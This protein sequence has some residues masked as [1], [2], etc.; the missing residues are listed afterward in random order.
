MRD[1]FAVQSD[2][3]RNIVTALAVT[4]TDEEKEVVARRHT[5]SVE[6]YDLF[7]QGQAYYV[8]NLRDDNL[9]ARDY[10][11]RALTLDDGF[12]RAHAALALTYADDFRFSWGQDPSVS[13]LAALRHAERA[14]AL[15]AR[16]P[17]AHFVLGYVHLF[18]HKNHASALKMG[19]RTVA[20]DPNHADGHALLAVSHVY[21]GDPETAVRH[22]ER[23]MRLNPIHPVR[24]LSILGYAHYF[25]GRYDKA[26]AAL[27]QALEQNPVRLIPQL[28]LV[29]SLVRQGK[30]SDDPWL[31]DT[32]RSGHPEFKL[33]AWADA[34]PFADRARLRKIVDDLQRAGLGK[35]EPKT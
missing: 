11:L 30:L 6:A 23:A 1:L 21:V 20:L 15:D 8:H 32:I 2:V 28:Y 14:V 26:R 25:A 19:E 33:Q 3:T 4:L 16:S 13:A 17:Q 34:Q 22:I 27:E 12:T 24:Y 29:A 18:A 35:Y 31:I 7:L 10:F 5:R 9:K